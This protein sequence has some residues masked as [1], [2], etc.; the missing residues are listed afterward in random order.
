MYFLCEE[1][2]KEL[3]EGL[4]AV[5]YVCFLDGLEKHSRPRRTRRKKLRITN[6]NVVR[7]TNEVK[8]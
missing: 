6:S 1:S 3:H 4:C 8:V 2:T 5:C 7:T